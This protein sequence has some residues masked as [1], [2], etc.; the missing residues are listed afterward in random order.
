MNSIK[1]AVFDFDMTLADSSWAI[2]DCTNQLAE[3][4]GLREV[5]REEV[6]AT[7][8]LPIEQCWIQLW[9]DFHEEWLEYYRSQFRG[10]ELAAIRPYPS[11]VASLEALRAAGVKTGVVSNRKFARKV[12]D[13]T[14][15]AP[16]MDVIIG[17]EDV[18]KAKPAPEALHTA[19]ARLGVSPEETIYVGD[20]DIDMQAAMAAG[21]RGV[22]M[23]TGN[24]EAA[25]L[26]DAGAWRSAD[27]LAEIPAICG[28]K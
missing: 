1:C 16:Y 8:G 22:G 12:L 11:A 18:T 28:L 9:G 21:V 2:H 20:T 23:T 24:F 15:L 17:L 19:M 26:I 6:L 7:I 3:R 5:S 14:K 13:A 27:D 10:A 4:F 25:A